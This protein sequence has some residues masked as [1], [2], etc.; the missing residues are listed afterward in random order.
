M[1]KNFPLPFI[2]L[3]LKLK[4]FCLSFYKIMNRFLKIQSFDNDI[5]WFEF[6][7]LKFIFSVIVYFMIKYL[8]FY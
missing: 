8:L 6:L 2:K 5:K 1:H 7:F 4:L 3:I